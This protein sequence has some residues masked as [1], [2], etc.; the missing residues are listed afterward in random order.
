MLDLYPEH[1]TSTGANYLEKWRN[2]LG[3]LVQLLLGDG[4]HPGAAR[5]Q[6]HRRGFEG[7]LERKHEVVILPSAHRR[8]PAGG[9]EGVGEWPHMG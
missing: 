9:R 5:V 2:F 1:C 3:N 7:L 8:V 6:P 4:V